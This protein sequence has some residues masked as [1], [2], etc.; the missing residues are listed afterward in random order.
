MTICI[1]FVNEHAD[2]LLQ[3]M[4]NF[5][6]DDMWYL[7]MGASRHMIDMK[8]FPQSL[9]K[10][11]K[12]VVRFGDDSSVRYKG[13]GEVHVEYTNSERMI[14]ENVLYI[15]KLKTNIL[16]LG[17]LDSQGCDIHLRNGFLTLYDGHGR[18]LT[19]TP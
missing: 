10:S 13:K 6:I 19:N 1:R 11:H 3:G 9:D 17:K 7:N 12:G 4:N 2:V 18:L 8:T 14:F 16:S 15:P 5:P